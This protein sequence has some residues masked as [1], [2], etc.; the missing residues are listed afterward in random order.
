LPPAYR[1]LLEH[2]HARYAALASTSLDAG[3]LEATS[4]GA[5]AFLAACAVL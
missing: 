5:H 1:A 3:L 4:P 2:R